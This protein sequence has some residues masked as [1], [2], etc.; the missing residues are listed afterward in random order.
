MAAPLLPSAGSDRLAKG[1]VQLLA[2]AN[3]S[4]IKTFGEKL[5]TVCF[6][7]RDFQLNFVIAASSVPII[8]ADF[9]CAHDYWL[10]LL[11]DV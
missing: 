7:Y 2:A 3:S 9:L 6:H 4:P 5:V 8:G 11:T 10:M 1:C